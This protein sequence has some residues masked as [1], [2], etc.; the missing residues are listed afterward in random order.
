MAAVDATTTRIIK[1]LAC[2]LLE[3]VI[4]FELPLRRAVVLYEMSSPYLPEL[5]PKV[6]SI[7]L[8]RSA[9]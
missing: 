2:M 4:V 1:L 6:K 9:Q 7:R 3:L 5:T 8:P